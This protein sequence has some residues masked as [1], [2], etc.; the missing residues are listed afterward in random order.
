VVKSQFV[1]RSI[2]AIAIGLALCG[3]LFFLW[4]TWYS[5]EALG[6]PAYFHRLIGTSVAA[7]DALVTCTSPGSHVY[8]Y[9]VSI[10]VIDAFLNKP[11]ALEAYPVRAGYQ[12]SHTMTHWHRQS[13]DPEDSL[14]TFTAL[15][16]VSDALRGQCRPA[17]AELRE[18]FELAARDPTS[19]ISYSYMRAG[20][21]IDVLSF[22]V[23]DRRMGVLYDVEAA[24]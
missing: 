1:F 15:A 8:A 18:A 19:F 2:G 6:R 7:E 23:L 20:D 17:W 3:G 22:Y 14:Y 12:E 24:A 21:R 5:D 9:R 13:W 4:V 10:Q 16:T 11:G